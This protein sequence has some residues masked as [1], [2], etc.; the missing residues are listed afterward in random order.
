MPKPPTNHSKTPSPTR[1]V[2]TSFLVDISDIVLNLIVASLTGSV[3]LTTQALQG[4]ADVSASGLT[5]IGIKR[6]AKPADPGHPFGYGREVYFWTILSGMVMFTVTTTLSFYLGFQRFQHP[7]TIENLPLAFAVL[8]I[9]FFTNGYALTQS[10]SRLIGD[11]H[12]AH[13]IHIFFNS[14]KIETK[15]AFI[16]NLT[17]TLT[18][19]TGTLALSLYSITGNIQ[20]DGLGAMAIAILMGLLTIVLIIN[21]KDLIVG[22]R[23]NQEIEQLIRTTAESHP[24]VTEVL[25]LRTIMIGSE[26][27]LINIEVHLRHNLSTQQIENIIDAIKAS[28]TDHVPQT[29][30]IQVE[31]EHNHK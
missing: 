7:Q 6:A 24:D 26:K 11:R 30:H 15:V 17:G 14:T 27:I 1:V 18:A 8:A 25:D 31:I 5:L 12:L 10:Y 2:T 16:L 29:T 23:A 4:I 9:G 19:I 21:V 20:F 3:V 28:I 13:L 22:R